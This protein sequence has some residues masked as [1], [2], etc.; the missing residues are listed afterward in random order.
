MKLTPWIGWGMG[1]TVLAGVGSLAH[2][3]VYIPKGRAQSQ[4]APIKSA[5]D[6][7][8]TVPGLSRIPRSFLIGDGFKF[9]LSGKELRIDHMATHSNAPISHR[10]CMISLNVDSPVA[11]FG[12]SMEIPLFNAQNLSSWGVSSLGDYVL[13]FAKDASVEHPTVGLKVSARF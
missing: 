5:E 13:H 1:V 8:S 4:I 3:D 11:F 2:A 10:N 7:V 6:A 9:K 12:S